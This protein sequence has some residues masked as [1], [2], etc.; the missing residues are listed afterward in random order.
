MKNST[1]NIGFDLRIHFLDNQQLRFSNSKISIVSESEN[2]FFVLDPNSV[3]SYEKNLIEIE[4][5]K[6]KNKK[7]VFLKNCNVLVS[8]NN[9]WVNSSNKKNLY[10]KTNKKINNKEK[11]KTLSKEL[12]EFNL[13]QKIGI[14]FEDFLKISE[15]EYQ[16]YKE[17]MKELFKLEEF[18]HEK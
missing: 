11:I 8:D 2:Q 7:Y 1:N 3:A 4:N 15:I 6:T 16:I 5:L 17:Q 14:D 10:E 18:E 9:I 12:A 13:M